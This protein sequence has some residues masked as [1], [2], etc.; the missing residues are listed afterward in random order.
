MRGNGFALT[1]KEMD[2]IGRDKKRSDMERTGADL[3]RFGID[4]M[5]FDM[6]RNSEEKHRIEME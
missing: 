5:G 4:W 2:L 1:R 6:E 3:K